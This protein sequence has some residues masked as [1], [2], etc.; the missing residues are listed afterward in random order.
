MCPSRDGGD[1]RP[2]SSDGAT[3]DEL[4]GIQLELLVPVAIPAIMPLSWDFVARWC[5]SFGSAEQRQPEQGRNRRSGLVSE[6][7]A[8]SGKT[9]T[10]P[11]P[12]GVG[13]LFLAGFAV[14]SQLVRRPHTI[15]STF[16][17]RVTR[18]SPPYGP[19][20]NGNPAQLDTG[21]GFPRS[22]SAR[23]PGHPSVP[24]TPR[25]GHGLPLDAGE[26]FPAVKMHVAVNLDHIPPR[27]YRR[28]RHL[29]GPRCPRPGT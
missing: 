25:V 5:A 11:P 20:G 4:V 15:Y 12:D 6:L 1:E 29:P 23:S 7:L 8:H 26:E 22:G 3:K 17:W 14:M 27:Q 10:E 9:R 13:S 21:R 16:P 18:I 2:D 28:R 24:S 19:P